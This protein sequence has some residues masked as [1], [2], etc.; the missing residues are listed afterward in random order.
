MT[1]A[2]TEHERGTRYMRLR[3]HGVDAPPTSIA[4][5]D[6]HSDYGS[7]LDERL[8][9]ELLSQAETDASKHLVPESVEEDASAVTVARVPK[10][11]SAEQDD[12]EY[13]TALEEQVLDTSPV[14]LESDAAVVYAPPKRRWFAAAQGD[15]LTR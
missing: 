8:V 15:W 3:R 7:D 6:D 14:A 4:I 13:F 1:M 9:H 12:E 11:P 10:R 2:R 5:D